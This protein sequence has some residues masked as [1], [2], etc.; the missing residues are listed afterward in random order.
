MD[1]LRDAIN[2]G[3]GMCICSQ[4]KE[5]SPEATAALDKVCNGNVAKAREQCQLL[6]D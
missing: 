1:D 4:L 2:D 3:P 5:L 6:R